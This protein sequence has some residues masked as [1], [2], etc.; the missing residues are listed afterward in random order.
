MPKEV[1]QMIRDLMKILERELGQPL[2]SDM[3]QRLEAQLCQQ[4]GGERVYVP[5]LPK[6]Q[7]QVRLTHLSTSTAATHEDAARLG[8]S[9]RQV[10]RIR[11]GR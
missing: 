9:V 3:P 11:R 8:L 10:R 1:S 7:H 4:Y 5:K 6:L 2:P